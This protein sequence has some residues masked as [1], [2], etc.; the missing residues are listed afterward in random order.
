M[1]EHKT[2]LGV[3]FTENTKKHKF[4]EELTK[5]SLK[6][7]I[8]IDSYDEITLH[9]IKDYDSEYYYEEDSFFWVK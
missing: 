1:K 7:G 9:K 5:L 6:Y 3:T 8:Y 4:I 2:V